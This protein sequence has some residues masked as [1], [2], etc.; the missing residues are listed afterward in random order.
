M[1]SRRTAEDGAPFSCNEN[2]E[3]DVTDDGDVTLFEV[4]KSESESMI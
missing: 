2:E 4:L 1:N 3:L